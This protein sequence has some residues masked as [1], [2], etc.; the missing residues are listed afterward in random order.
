MA[1]EHPLRQLRGCFVTNDG[2][3]SSR[4]GVPCQ[5]MPARSEQASRAQAAG[6]ADIADKP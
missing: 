2:L 6:V 4:A 5:R 1:D 3:P